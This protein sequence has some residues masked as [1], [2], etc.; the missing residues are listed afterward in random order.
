MSELISKSQRQTLEKLN[1]EIERIY[2][3]EDY[4]QCEKMIVK[5][6]GD[7]PHAPHPHNLYGIIL[8]KYGDK[9]AAMNHYRAAIALEPSFKPARC[10]L[11]RYGDMSNRDTRPAFSEKD[12]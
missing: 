7:Y 4:A 10:N 5:A 9:H 3:E 11:N 1:D 12:C 2:L 8:E 6:I